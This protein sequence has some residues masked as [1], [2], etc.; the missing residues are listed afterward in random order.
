MTLADHDRSAPSTRKGLRILLPAALAAGLALPLAACKSSA[1]KAE[2]YYQS[3]LTFL[4]Q[5][6][7]DR[8][9]VQ[10]RNV[11]EIEGTHYEA[12]KTLA[13]AL[14][15]RGDV[16]GAY[17]QYLRLAEQYPDDL[18][19]RVALARMAFAGSNPEEFDR[20]AQRAIEIAPEDIEAKV[21]DLA[22]R[23]REALRSENEAER[24]RL[25][26]EGA[27]LAESRPDDA[28]LL[29]MALDKAAREKDL[30]RADEMT[31]K[32]LE[33]QP[34]N[35]L[36][37]AQRLALLVEQGDV[38]A[39]EDH[40]RAT[41]AQFP[42][43][44]EAK[45]DL[46]SFLM[47][48][49]QPDKAEAFLRELAAAAPADQP[50]PKV[51]LL[52]FI[53]I[54]QGAQAAREELGRILSEGGD[55]LL[56][57]SMLAGFDFRDGKTAESIEAI[58][59]LLENVA[60]PSDLS[61]DVRVQL[62]RMLLATGD[63]AGTDQQVD[64][65][66]AQN[67]AHAG[68][69]KL[70]AGRDIRA[71]RTDDAIL[72]LRS[73]LDAAPQDI[74]AMNLMAEAYHRAGEPELARDYL[75]QAA[76]ASGNAPAESLRLAQVLAEEERWRPA[77]DTLVAALRVSPDNADLLMML[78]RVY[79]AM[80][81]IP[82]A[83]GV[84]ARL[85]ELGDPRAKAMADQLELN[86]LAGEEGR[87]AAM[88]YLEQLAG[89]TDA[90]LGPKLDLLR[91][92]LSSGD[93]E[94]ARSIA[95]ELAEEAPGSQ[96]VEMA[97]AMTDAAA[98]DIDA[99][100]DRLRKLIEADPANPT[101][102]MALIRMASFTGDREGALA[103]IE[104]GLAAMP[105]HPDLLWSKAGILESQGDIDGTIAI[106]EQLY[107]RD[108]GS[109]ITANNLASTLA[110]WR[111][112][113]Q[114]AVA[115]AT[116]VARRL[117]DTQVPAFM[118]TYGWVQHLNGSSAEALPYLEGAAAALANDPMV[119]IHL[120]LAQEATGKIDAAREQLQKALDMLP[121]GQEGA[122]IARAREVLAGLRNTD[123]GTDGGTDQGEAASDQ[124]AP[125]N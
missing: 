63:R 31:G 20:H 53:E 82:R 1:E 116:A 51:D 90:G 3:G 107:A 93:V 73:V 108:S 67:P 28:L 33:L 72:A 13:E 52:R 86:R 22:R 46:I 88:G 25:G 125:A 48:Q 105:D 114:G 19:V 38:A 6:D 94:G 23:Y 49:N 110:T 36:R 117:K 15:G 84:I 8:A 64:E 102:Y 32:L 35:R 91:A 2:E 104:E 123:P 34:D 121:E 50:G 70:R 47:S 11:F 75:A 26:E 122:S 74:E 65:V 81:D 112:D 39:V 119:Q 68:A 62:A 109:L 55:P 17:S 59:K 71:D 103:V 77:E 21:L 12:R 66:L 99:A 79:L 42:D 4:E 24:I 87:E 27:A 10:F 96:P 41:V 7:V 56:F 9:I 83:E 43:E 30:G 101:A 61:R 58:R 80:P 45:R 69:L 37:Y 14:A 60:E 16:G 120:G 29:G 5:G 18:A 40:L 54:R 85:Q 124:A 111:S 92:K 100:R 115:R 118:D 95:R 97:L 78:G 76:T 89:Q 106:Y 98:G 44:P 113:D 57:G